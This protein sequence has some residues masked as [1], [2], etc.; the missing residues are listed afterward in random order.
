[1]AEWWL[2][3]H[4]CLLGQ[5]VGIYLQH[6]TSDDPWTTMDRASMAVSLEARV[7]P[8]CPTSASGV[9]LGD[10]RRLHDEGYFHPEPI[11]EAWEQ[12]VQ[13][14]AGTHQW[15]HALWTVL[16]FQAWHEQNR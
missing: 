15:E 10:G 5:M 9:F 4:P 16:M 6:D 11:R 2:L 7:L 8:V 12:H 1:M 13:H 14:V 3:R